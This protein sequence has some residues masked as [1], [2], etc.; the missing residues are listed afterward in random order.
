MRDVLYLDLSCSCTKF[1]SGSIFKD[2]FLVYIF[3]LLYLLFFNRETLSSS[4]PTSWK[5][6][7]RMGRPRPSN[8]TLPLPWRCVWGFWIWRTDGNSFVDPSWSR[9][10]FCLHTLQVLTVCWRMRL[11]NRI[12]G[13]CWHKS[14]E[15]LLKWSFC[16]LHVKKTGEKLAFFSHF[17]QQIQYVIE[18]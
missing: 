12:F 6:I 9:R 16:C 4:S 14:T 15:I 5:C 1:L 2:G 11:N 3:L 18:G 7:L 10:R 17:P 8:S 13:Q